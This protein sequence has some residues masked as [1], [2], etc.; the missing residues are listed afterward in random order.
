MAARDLSRI[1]FGATV[2][3]GQPGMSAGSRF[4]IDMSRTALASLAD[5]LKRHAGS[6]SVDAVTITLGSA[7]F[8]LEVT[9]APGSDEPKQ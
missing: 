7:G 3:L 6:F 9:K 4:V 2:E 8:G 5:E 1:I